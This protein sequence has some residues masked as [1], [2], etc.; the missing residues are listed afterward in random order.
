MINKSEQEIM[1]NWGGDMMVSITCVAFNHESFIEETLDS[2]LMQETNFPFEILINDDASIDETVSILK[3]Y[4][5]NFPNIVKPLYQS[6]NQ[7]SKGINTMAL[8]FPYIKGKYVAFCDGDD[9]WIDN[10]KLQIQVDAMQEHPELDL[11][12]HPSYRVVNGKRTE[13]L[14]KH[15][16]KNTKFT[17]QHS[18]A[19]HGDFAETASLMFTRA[20]ID[21]LPD[22]FLTASPGDYV[23][24]VMGA[25][26]GGSLYIDRIMSV[27]RS[28]LI[29]GW[30]E[31]EL[32]KTTE[33]RKQ[34]LVNIIEQL[35]FLDKYL[36][37]KFTQDFKRVIHKDIFVFITSVN[38]DIRIKK[39]LYEQHRLNFTII[40]KFKWH[41]LFKHQDL[42]EVL[43]SIKIKLKKQS[44]VLKISTQK[45][46]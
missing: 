10:E 4:E 33:E 37:Y 23:S 22:W 2:F 40:E 26:R 28:G 3:K 14:S 18:I 29:E 24:E 7:Y 13:I 39:E 31:Q 5:K 41:L 20:L 35:E 9:Y 45:I 6:K 11:C 1:K 27:Y 25:V 44:E 8:L 30:T 34:T 46:N 38:N 17:I 15:A 42:I 12:F 32:Q 43:K 19:G 21:S 36:D 16:K